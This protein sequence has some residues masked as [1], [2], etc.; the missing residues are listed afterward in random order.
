LN[1][2]IFIP[3]LLVSSS[4]EAADSASLAR[5]MA[6]GRRQVAAEPL[7]VML[8]RLS[9]VQK[10]KDWPLAAVSLLGEEGAVQDGC[11]MRADPVHLVLQRD[12]FSLAETVPLKISPHDSQLLVTAL[13]KHFSPEGMEFYLAK[14]GAWYVHMDA[15]PDVSTTL[16]LTA[17]GRDINEYLPHGADAANWN[18]LLNEVQMLLH[19]HPVNQAREAA[20]E[21]AVNSIWPSGGGMLPVAREAEHRVI[22]S[23]DFL[24]NGLGILSKSSCQILPGDMSAILRH[25]ANDEAWLVLDGSGNVEERWFAPT[26][27]ALRQRKIGRLVMSFAVRDQVLNVI[28][29]PSDLWKF[30]RRQKPMHTYFTAGN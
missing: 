1:L 8:C 24:V 16:P 21:L 6:A 15:Q 5:L 29:Q 7:E 19:D 20:G 9:G 22:F 27:A 28:V 10:Q 3:Y 13:H 30:W 14:S 2:R 17:A 26:L 4:N 18:R 25:P 11:W 23:N 12:S